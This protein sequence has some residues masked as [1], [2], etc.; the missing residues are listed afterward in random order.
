MDVLTDEQ[1]KIYEHYNYCT[2]VTNLTQKFLT[3]ETISYLERS[4]RGQTK[5]PLWMLLR[6]DRRTASGASNFLSCQNSEAFQFGHDQESEIKKHAGL[7]A[8][9]QG[10]IEEQL[11]C[12]ITEVVLDCGMFFSRMGLYSA[13]PD[14]FFATDTGL[15][16]PLEI[17]SPITYKDVTIDEIRNKMNAKKNRYRV[18]HTAF[19]L[20]KLGDYCFQVEKTDPHYRQMQRQIYVMDAPICIYLV[21][22]KNAF[23]AATVFRDKKFYSD[24]LQRET[25]LFNSFIKSN[26]NSNKMRIQSERIRTFPSNVGSEN[27]LKLSSL[28]LY[29]TYDQELKCA[30]CGL[31]NDCQVPIST[32]QILHRDC[33][34]DLRNENIVSCVH[35]DFFNHQARVHSLLQVNADSLAAKWGCFYDS[36]SNLFRTFCCDSIVA[37]LMVPTHKESCAYLKLIDDNG[38]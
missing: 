21:K 9:I 10:Q 20:N 25:F 34:G 38:L 35:T 37:D 5:N 13:S 23:V 29:W 24:E 27:I 7:V 8:L 22:F 4:T 12:N 30:I 19:S 3:N 33:K 16:I 6:L 1:K 15:R 28:G 26:K 32:L 36:K 2:Y 11:G 31:K 18:K 14:A 17:K